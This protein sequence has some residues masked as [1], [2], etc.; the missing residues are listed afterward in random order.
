MAEPVSTSVV[1]TAFVAGVAQEA[2]KKIGGYAADKAIQ[3]WED[4][5]QRHDDAV[6]SAFIAV[7]ILI[8]TRLR[9]V[10]IG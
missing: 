7:A 5:W 2:G 1:A 9:L 6:E 8:R 3:E 10:V 4:G